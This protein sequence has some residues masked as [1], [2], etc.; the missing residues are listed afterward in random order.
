MSC[1]ELPAS[2]KPEE[3]NKT[4]EMSKLRQ[5]LIAMRKVKR[6]MA[7]RAA[8]LRHPARLTTPTLGEFLSE[9]ITSMTPWPTED[10]PASTLKR[11]TGQ[12]AD[13]QALSEDWANIGNDLRAAFVI[14]ERERDL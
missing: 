2:R 10:R 9:S 6:G 12:S 3:A 1:S 11:P 8:K 4:D 14:Y 7:P 13:L 5:R